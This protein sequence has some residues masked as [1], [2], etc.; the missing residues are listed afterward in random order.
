MIQSGILFSRSDSYGKDGF[1]QIITKD[2]W[3]ALKLYYSLLNDEPDTEKTHADV[4]RML[5]RSKRF[6]KKW[7]KVI[8]VVEGLGG[9]GE[10]S[11]RQ[12]NERHGNDKITLVDLTAQIE[13][14]PGDFFDDCFAQK[15]GDDLFMNKRYYSMH[16]YY[17]RCYQGPY[18]EPKIKLSTVHGAKGLESDC[19]ILFVF[20]DRRWDIDERLKLYLNAMCRSSGELIITGEYSRLFYDI[21]GVAPDPWIGAT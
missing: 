3:L 9:R 14:T 7:R 16:E 17:D 8:G 12:Y 5:R 19:V 20:G 6:T 1:G 4:S 15:R 10:G 11:Q 2:D 21:L 18:M 13:L